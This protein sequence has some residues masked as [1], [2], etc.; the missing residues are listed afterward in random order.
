MTIRPFVCGNNCSVKCDECDPWNLTDSGSKVQ[1]LASIR[2][3]NVLEL[4]GYGSSSIYES[5]KL[6][7]IVFLAMNMLGT[8]VSTNAMVEHESLCLTFHSEWVVAVCYTLTLDVA[9]SNVYSGTGQVR[10]ACCAGVLACLALAVS[11]I[12]R[13]RGLSCASLSPRRP[14]APGRRLR[15]ADAPVR[16][17]PPSEGVRAEPS[18]QDREPADTRHTTPFIYCTL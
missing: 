1:I 2:I 11:L 18:F 3:S 16:L 7:C 9:G 15:S 8:Y 13:G 12:D 10:F 4:S 14:V 6:A 5:D 17:S